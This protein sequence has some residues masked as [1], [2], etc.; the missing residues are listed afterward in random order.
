MTTEPK[1]SLK[2]LVDKL[3]NKVL[4]AEASKEVVDFLFN[5]FYLC[6]WAL[7]LG[8]LQNNKWWVASQTFMRVLKY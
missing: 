3:D 6:L 4:F 8:F 2:L 7:S 1:L 5:T